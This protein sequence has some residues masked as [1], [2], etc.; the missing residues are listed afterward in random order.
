[1]PLKDGRKKFRVRYM[2]QIDLQLMV[3]P[4]L[5]LIFIFAYLPMYG[6]LMSF[7]D[8]DI[9]GGFF[10]SPWVGFKHFKMF[11][12]SPDFWNVMRNTIVISF[13]R[14]LIGFPAPI[15]LALILNEVAHIRFKRIVQTIS[16]LPHFLSWV[17]VSGLAMSILA[18]ENGSLNMLLE[19]FNLINEPINFLSIPNYFWGILI[20]TGVWK[21]IGFS[22]IVYIAA[23]A[24]INP[25]VYEAASIDGATRLKKIM[26]ITIPGIAGVIIIFMILAVGD[27]LSAGFE[28][29]LL[30]AK[31]PVLQDVSDVIDT[32][33]YRVGIK[34]SRFSYAAAVGLY[35]SIISVALLTIANA[36][37]RKLGRSLW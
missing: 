13:L 22:A 19:N 9:F 18:T 7:Q 23:I 30:L 11:F 31:N 24:G 15:I 35:K 17:I 36:I 10:H 20:S 21:E 8:Y 26:Y 34:N 25:E 16:Y 2:E 33:V 5:V 29:I 32:Y 3:I 37:A 28:D 6:V 14:L 27:I 4:A 12:D 1:M